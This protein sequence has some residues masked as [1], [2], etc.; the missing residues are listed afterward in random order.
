MDLSLNRIY[1]KRLYSIR[2]N[3]YLRVN[4]DDEKFID[5]WLAMCDMVES[6]WWRRAWAYQEFISSTQSHFSCGRQ[7]IAWIRLSQIFA[8]DCG[9][10]R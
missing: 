2:L 1:S 5:D 8:S 9:I 7:S 6:R 4:N 10:N 3:E